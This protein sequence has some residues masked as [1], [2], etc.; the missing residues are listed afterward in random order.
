MSEDVVARLRGHIASLP[1]GQLACPICH[2]TKWDLG[3]PDGDP[4]GGFVSPW[5]GP[6]PRHGKAVVEMLILCCD[7]CGYLC[8]FLWSRVGR[9]AAEPSA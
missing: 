4:V 3:G 9:M 7:S 5:I 1:E 2:G 8:H 6:D